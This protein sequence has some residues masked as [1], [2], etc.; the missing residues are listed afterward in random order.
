MI[1]V[2]PDEMLRNVAFHQDLQSLL[3]QKMYPKV[4]ET[5]HRILVATL[6]VYACT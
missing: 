5:A 6:I 4:R 1:N 2:D 3:R